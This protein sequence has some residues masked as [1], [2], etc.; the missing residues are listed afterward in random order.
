MAESLAELDTL[1]QTE[2]AAMGSRGRALVEAQF[3]WDHVADQMRQLYDWTLGG[4]APPVFVE[5]D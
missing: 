1:S 3:S 5:T 2:L 4:G